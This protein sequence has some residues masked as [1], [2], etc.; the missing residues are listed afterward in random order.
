M[1]APLGALDHAMNTQRLL[2]ALALTGGLAL[3]GYWYW[4]SEDWSVHA[5][6][7]PTAAADLDTAL[8]SRTGRGAA[9]VGRSEE[10]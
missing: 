5:E 8:L 9:L 4:A 7:T 6:P 2:T 10:E 1:D 3:G